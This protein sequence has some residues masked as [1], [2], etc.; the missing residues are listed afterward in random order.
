MSSVEL[1][2]FLFPI[3]ISYNLRYVHLIWRYF[4]TYTKLF[5][6]QFYFEIDWSCC[7]CRFHYHTFDRTQWLNQLLK[8]II[9]Y[10]AWMVQHKF[11][12]EIIFLPLIWRW[13]SLFLFLISWPFLRRHDLTILCAHFEVSHCEPAFLSSFL[14]I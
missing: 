6:Y 5:Y 11:W 4:G 2:Y 7:C 9:S 1:C 14:Y 10:L 3:S 8:I 13:L 12:I